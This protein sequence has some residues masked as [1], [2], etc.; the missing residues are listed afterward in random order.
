MNE[1]KRT[2]ML[3]GVVTHYYARPGAAVVR[4]IRNVPLKTHIYFHGKTTNFE[5]DIDSLEYNR[6]P[7]DLAKMNHNVGVSV[8]ERV[9]KGDRVY[10]FV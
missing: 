4:F 8:T 1:T 5:E 9:R 7:T 10:T 6:F 2:L 3:V